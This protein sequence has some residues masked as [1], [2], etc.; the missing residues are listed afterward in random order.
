MYYKNKSAYTYSPILINLC[1]RKLK[2]E[3]IDGKIKEN[4]YMNINFTIDHRF[5]DG[6]LGGKLA[7][8][9]N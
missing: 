5:L 3:N 7:N 4:T 8:E 2:R 1:K 9:V 6:S